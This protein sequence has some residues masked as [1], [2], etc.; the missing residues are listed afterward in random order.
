MH[1]SS[2]LDDSGGKSGTA[3]LAKSHAEIEK[4]GLAH[5]IQSPAMPGFGR[6][7]SK[8][9]MVD[10]TFV[11]REDDRRS[12]TCYVAVDD[13]RHMIEAGGKDCTAMAAISRPPRRRRTSS[14]SAR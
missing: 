11:E 6:D 2:G 7:V 5:A 13:H 14:G 1:G 4:R 8:Q 10:P 3:T 12:S 9:A